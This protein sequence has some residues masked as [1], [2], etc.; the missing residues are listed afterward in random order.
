MAYNLSETLKENK[1][2]LECKDYRKIKNL[3]DDISKKRFESRSNNIH[4]YL[5]ST[6]PSYTM[7][8]KDFEI[9]SV[10]VSLQKRP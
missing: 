7:E 10:G 8:G 3:I 4:P 6:S 5:S 1:L 9:Q 2:E